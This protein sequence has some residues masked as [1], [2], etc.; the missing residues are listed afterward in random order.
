MDTPQE[1]KDLQAL[2]NRRHRIVWKPFMDKYGIKSVCEIGV[3][4]SQNFRRLLEGNPDIAVGI[5]TWIEDGNVARNDSGF[6]QER[7]DRQCDFFMSLMREHPSVRLYRELSSEAHKHFP[8]E[9]FD[10]IYIDADHTYEGCYADLNAWFP[11]VKKGR[12]FTGDDFTD[13]YKTSSGVKFGVKSA[14]DRFCKENNLVYYEL[15]RTRW[16]ILK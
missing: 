10:L 3:F 9:Y 16:A 13:N 8:D 7:L 14:V 6:D 12:F 1:I 5:D 15:P 11:K 2:E 4:E